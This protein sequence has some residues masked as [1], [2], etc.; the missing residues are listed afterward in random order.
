MQPYRAYGTDGCILFSDILTPLPAMGVK[1]DILE[2]SGPK[3]KPFSTK[4]DVSNIQI[5]DPVKHTP[6]VGKILNNLRKEVDQNT[7]VLG[8]IGLP[9]TIA[10]YLV[11]GEGTSEY[12]KIKS[13][14]YN[15]PT[16]LHTLLYKLAE[17][18]ALYA[19]Y[20]IDNGAQVIQIFDSWA[21]VLSPED[22]ENFALP[23]QQI[24]VRN[25]KQ[26]HPDVPLILYINRAG[27]LLESLPLSGAD[28][29]SL[30]WT[31]NT[32]TARQKFGP[33]VG[34]QGN[35][36]PMV[37]F[38][39]NEVIVSKTTEILKSLGGHRHIMN[40][41]HGIDSSTSEEKAKLFVDT[42]KSWSPAAL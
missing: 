4:E 25:I 3:I 11:E 42:V 31:T 36:D 17:N 22:Y 19:N 32:T 21:G 20:Q 30:D 27:A 37:L 24:V 33:D 16:I 18:L 12:K 2:S 34:I 5:I 26:L 28:V 14:M 13:M 35:L 39:P 7:A 1:F 41:G 38:G 9:F 23:Y 29:I 40:L 8:F 10:C 15:D 6:F